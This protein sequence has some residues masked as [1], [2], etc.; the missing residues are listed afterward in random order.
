[1]D[2]SDFFPEFFLDMFC[3]FYFA[4]ILNENLDSIL[5]WCNNASS[6]KPSEFP[7]F[8]DCLYY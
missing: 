6:S 2:A 4:L 3:D 8:I 7:I 5:P 1:M